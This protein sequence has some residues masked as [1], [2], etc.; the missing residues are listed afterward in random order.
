MDFAMHYTE[1]QEKFRQEVQAWIKENAPE[2][3]KPLKP[4]VSPV[5]WSL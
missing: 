1:E 5:S 4:T 3:R 2:N